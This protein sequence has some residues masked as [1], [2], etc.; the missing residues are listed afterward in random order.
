[1]ACQ[2]FQTNCICVIKYI[3]LLGKKHPTVHKHIYL[4]IILHGFA[5]VCIQFF[6]TLNMDVHP[7]KTR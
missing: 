2:K 7:P 4:K 6:L 3:C 5:A 1:M